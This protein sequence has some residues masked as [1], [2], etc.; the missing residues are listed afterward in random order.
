MMQ[1]KRW[2]YTLNN[3]TDE[4]YERL[5]LLECIYHIIGKEVGEQGTPHLQAFICFDTNQRFD[6]V[7]LLLGDR[8]H[9]E[10]ARGTTQQALDYC[11]KDGDFI[12]YGS[13]PIRQGKRT[14]WDCFREWVRDLDRLPTRREIASEYPHLWARY[15]QR[16]LEI[17]ESFLPPPV[18]TG[19]EPRAG[20]QTRL[21]DIL[22]GPV[23]P[24]KITFVVDQHGNSG[25]SWFCQYMITKHSDRTQVLRIGKRDDLSY[26]IDISKDIFLFDVPRG[27]LQYLQYSVLESLKDRMIFSPKYESTFKVL[28]KLPHV[29]C[30]TNEEPDKKQLS[31]DRFQIIK[32]RQLV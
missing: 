11:K 30:F 1:G 12:E 15:S 18:L 2:C 10:L 27:Q 19:T 13:P 23:S 9:I 14:D 4:D 6:A 31:A 8:A 25:K 32:I 21:I 28:T 24:R 5:S 3:Y 17:A 7:K 29:V 20:W 16:C 22:Q 26:A